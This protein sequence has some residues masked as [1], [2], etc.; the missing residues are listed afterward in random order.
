MLLPIQ[1]NAISQRNFKPKPGEISNPYTW[2]V[3]CEAK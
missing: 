1:N 3:F 2:Y